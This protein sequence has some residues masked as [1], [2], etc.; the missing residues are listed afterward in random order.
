MLK[1]LN[2]SSILRVRYNIAQSACHLSTK[3]DK[4]NDELDPPI[5]A[6]PMAYNSYE[7]QSNDQNVAPVIIM[8]GNSS[9][10][11]KGLRLFFNK[12]YLFSYCS[13]LFG[14]KQNWR[15]IS[16]ALHMKSSPMRKVSAAFERR[17]GIC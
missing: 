15:S 7:N 10:I 6:L 1:A 11:I 17:K 16:K 8:H 14:S 9:K 5:K 2:T 4:S 13:G 3:T 12:N